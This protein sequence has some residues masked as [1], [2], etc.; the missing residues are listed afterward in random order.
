M[1]AAEAHA[2]SEGVRHLY[3]HVVADNTAAGALY[4]RMGFEVEA[5]ETESQAR[6]LGRPR[7]KI[8]HKALAGV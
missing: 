1:S 6:G 4:A 5:E 3:V 7:R 8:L 2:A